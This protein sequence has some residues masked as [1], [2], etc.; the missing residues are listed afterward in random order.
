MR[1]IIFVI[2]AAAAKARKK[3]ALSS[4]TSAFL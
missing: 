2:A 1:M 4:I 3:L